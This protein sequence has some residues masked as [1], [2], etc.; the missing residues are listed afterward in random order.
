MAQDLVEK[1]A[2]SF[3]EELGGNK[4][5][6]TTYIIVTTSYLYKSLKTYIGEYANGELANLLLLK[7]KPV[8]HQV[9]QH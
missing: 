6:R 8:F 2:T 5:V 9:I 1:Q 7:Y 3:G 4:V